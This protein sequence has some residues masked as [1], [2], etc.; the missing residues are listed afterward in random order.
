ML[1]LLTLWE[2]LPSLHF[3]CDLPL[4]RNAF[5]YPLHISTQLTHYPFMPSILHSVFYSPISQVTSFLLL[6]YNHVTKA[7]IKTTES[8]YLGPHL[9]L[10]SSYPIIHS[11]TC[12]FLWKITLAAVSSIYLHCHQ[13]ASQ[14]STSILVYHLV[15]LKHRSVFTHHTLPFF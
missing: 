8:P 5:P 1:K 4:T 10:H 6:V 13:F 14:L 3:S 2:W 12:F 15:F 7:R 9:L 11:V